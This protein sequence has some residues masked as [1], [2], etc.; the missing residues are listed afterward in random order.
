MIWALLPALRL[1]GG[2]VVQISSS[3]AWR[4]LPAAAAYSA[5]KACLD[6]FTESLRDEEAPR[7]ISV[8]SVHPGV[9][10]TPLRDR[11][12]YSG[13][14]PSSKGLIFPATASW[15]AEKIAGA[16]QA[17]RNRL[18]TVPWVLRLAMRSV[19][20]LWPGLADRLAKGKDARRP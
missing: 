8:L 11:A 6:R 3:L 16:I 14:R 10:T 18:V 12:L 20:L 15:T 1:S 5:S 9:I 2:Q 7:G 17:R 13:Q 19:V 4:S